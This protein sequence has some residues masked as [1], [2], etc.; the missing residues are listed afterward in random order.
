[1]TEHLDSRSDGRR[2]DQLRPVDFNLD[3]IIHPAGS[4]LVSFGQTRVLCNAS[5]QKDVPR[6]MAGKGRGWVTAEYDM[7]PSATHTRGQ[8]RTASP[9]GRAMEI[10]RLIGRS[11]RASIDLDRLGEKSIVIDA[12]VIQADGG[13]RTAAITGGF[14]ALAVACARLVA[15]GE[16]AEMPLTR[17]VAAVSAGIVDGKLAL[18]LHYDDDVRADVDLNLVM[19]NDGNLVEIQGTG[20]K[21]SFSPTQLTELVELAAGGCERLFQMQ[22]AALAGYPAAAY[23]WER[24]S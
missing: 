18:D 4:V 22:A 20:E 21:T 17:A 10:Q 12:D 24:Q 16:I 2:G 23:L 5:V 8:R 3:F 14:V 15:A 9:N 6:W 1:M 7:L 19:T 13:T 11:L